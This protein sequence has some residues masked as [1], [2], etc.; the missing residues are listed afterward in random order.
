MPI[1]VRTFY[2]GKIVEFKQEEKKMN[3][4]E[5]QKAKRKR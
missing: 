5:M 3:D 2:I 4:K 1:W